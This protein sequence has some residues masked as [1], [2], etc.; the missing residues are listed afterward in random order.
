LNQ[1]G[2]LN[3]KNDE[4]AGAESNNMG[5]VHAS[6][7]TAKK[8]QLRRKLLRQR[9]RMPSEVWRSRSALICQHLQNCSWFQEAHTILAY[10]STRQEPDLSVL[11]QQDQGQHRW[12]LPRCVGKTLRWHAWLPGDT[13][14]LQPGAYGIQEPHLD[15]PLL[16][17]AEVDLILVPAVACDRQGYRL[18]YGGGY[19]DRLLSDPAWVGKRSIGI[20][21]K[22][23][24]CPILPTDPWD[25]PLAAVC[26][27][28]RIFVNNPS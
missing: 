24:R 28:E 21:F 7:P 11:W 18:G 27:E 14:A 13:G 1:Y 26:T 2:P 8:A 23:S 6:T 17:S 4:N 15:L 12:G 20:T 22:F 3:L 9:E 16:A 5:D 19:Y 25:R 10:L